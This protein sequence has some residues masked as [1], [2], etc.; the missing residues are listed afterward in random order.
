MLVIENITVHQFPNLQ[1][2]HQKSDFKRTKMSQYSRTFTSED[3]FLAKNQTEYHQAPAT[4]NSLLF[5]HD[6]S[7]NYRDQS[8]LRKPI[9]S[10]FC[11][12]CL[13]I[14]IS[15]RKFLK[16]SLMIFVYRSGGK[17]VFA[18]Y[19]GCLV[20]SSFVLV[21]LK[22]QFKISTLNSVYAA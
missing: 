14:H 18:L 11:H 1:K 2:E 6:W 17:I 7:T 10:C 4:L 5:L 19:C 12:V 3:F 22:W 20:I 13:N 21:I 15:L 9:Y 16:F 8:C